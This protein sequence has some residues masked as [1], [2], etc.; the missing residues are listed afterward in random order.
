[1]L[2][3]RA[4]PS[5]D[6]LAVNEET[7]KNGAQT[8]AERASLSYVS[9]A[10]PGIRRLIKGKGFSYLGPNG[11][12]VDPATLDRIKAIVIPPAWT[13]VWISPDPNGHIQATGRDQRGRKQYRYHAQW[14]EERDGVKYSSLVAFAESLPGLRRQVDADLRRRGLPLE[15]VVASI[16]WLLDNT[17]IRVGNAA[18]ARDNKSFG[19]TTLR[20]RHVD[21]EGSSL[22]FAFKGKSGKEWKL[23]LVDRRI[24]RVVRGA[25]DLPGQKL[26]Q[27][28]GED[29]NRR[30]VRSEDVN[31]YIRAAAGAEFSSKHF[32]TWGG[33]I[34]AASLFAQAELPES[35]AQRKRAMNSIIDK[36]AE[37]LGNTR[38]VCR[39]CYIHPLVFEAWS[40]GRLLNEMAEANKRQRLINGLDEEET[41]VL[42]WLQAHG[43]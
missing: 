1:M 16:V 15:R 36:V 27:Y 25:Q 9:D 7:Q 24:A 18:Y 41:L 34:H 31:A 26:F 42:R 8:S 11:R 4:Q 29:G 37:R 21:I 22:R 30:P 38:A 13:D 5:S 2:Q 12:A 32:R 39:R 23:K 10:D 43:A 14:T 19:L 33:T 20:D 35:A 17:M 6:Q 28:L 3:Q 40:E